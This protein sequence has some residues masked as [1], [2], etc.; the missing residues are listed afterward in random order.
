MLTREYGWG[1]IVNSVILVSASE[2][3]KIVG[4]IGSMDV[5]SASM[6]AMVFWHGC[7][8]DSAGICN[9]QKNSHSGQ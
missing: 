8:L 5:I 6:D 9:L 3:M 1:L 4:R 7:L 2:L